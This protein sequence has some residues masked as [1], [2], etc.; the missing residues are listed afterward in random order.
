M[1]NFDID[2]IQMT[3]GIGAEVAAVATLAT[4]AWQHEHFDA[5]DRMMKKLDY[6]EVLDD[7]LLWRKS[8]RDKWVETGKESRAEKRYA[9]CAGF[10][11]NNM[12]QDLT[13]W[14]AAYAVSHSPQYNYMKTG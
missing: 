12:P 5:W 4:D 13:R 11:H 9:I 10:H 2:P 3:T 6:D 1:A 14:I 7:L 8:L